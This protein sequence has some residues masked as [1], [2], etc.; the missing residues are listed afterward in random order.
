MYDSPSQWWGRVILQW[1]ELVI[2]MI[3]DSTYVSQISQV[4]SSQKLI[5]KKVFIKVTVSAAISLRNGYNFSVARPL[6][7]MVTTLPQAQ[8]PRQFAQRPL[9]R[10]LIESRN[11]YEF[12]F[13][14]WTS[15]ACPPW[16]PSS[17]LAFVRTLLFFL[18]VI[19]G[20]R[21]YNLRSD[22]LLILIIAK[23]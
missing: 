4:R 7:T 15:E 16:I 23:S 2:Y 19:S 12:Y 20:K 11:T 10:G 9:N 8:K 21:K 6:M 18:L 13:S 14:L 3:V 22:K 1:L 17:L 5:M